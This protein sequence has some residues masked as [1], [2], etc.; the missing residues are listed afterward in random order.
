[1]LVRLLST[2]CY[3]QKLR[4]QVNRNIKKYGD[5]LNCAFK[6]TLEPEDD[7]QHILTSIIAKILLSYP[8]ILI[9]SWQKIAE[10]LNIKLRSMTLENLHIGNAKFKFSIILEE[11]M[12]LSY[13]PLLLLSMIIQQNYYYQYLL[14]EEHHHE[15]QQW[16]YITIDQINLLKNLNQ[17]L[18]QLQPKQTFTRMT[19]IS[20]VSLIIYFQDCIIV[21]DMIDT[22]STLSEVSKVL[23]EQ[24]AIRVFA[25]ATHALFSGKEFI[26]LSSPSLDQIIVIIYLPFNYYIN[27]IPSNPKK[28]RSQEK[29]SAD[30]LLISYLVN[31]S[32]SVCRGYLQK[33]SVSTLFNIV[34][35]Q[36]INQYQIYE[37]LIY[38]TISD[39]NFHFQIRFLTFRT[40]Q[41]FFRS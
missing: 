2:I 40:Q 11:K 34:S 14:Q 1:M 5:R 36:F 32:S 29:E 17:Q 8:V 23:K 13:N 20:N 6:W 3:R 25:F 16:W 33:E 4:L 19:E 26:N 24:G 21:D 30:C 35:L 7:F 12:F 27:I 28:M 31:I 9:K 39:I 38:Q 22:A 41:V 15:K 18:L 37:T 10:Y